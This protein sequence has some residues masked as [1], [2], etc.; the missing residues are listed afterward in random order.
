MPQRETPPLSITAGMIRG[1]LSD[2]GHV[3]LSGSVRNLG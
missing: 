3:P 2:G 1:L